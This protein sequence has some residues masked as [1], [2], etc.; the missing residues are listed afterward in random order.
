MAN[1]NSPTSNAVPPPS[2]PSIVN[3]KLDRSNYPLW[4]A[5]IVPLLNSRDLMSFVDGTSEC[6]PKN[7]AGSTTVN[8]AYTTWFQQDQLILSWINS[9]LTPSVLSTVSRNQTS[10]T[11]W[12]ALEHRYASASQNRILH[13]RNELLRTMKGDLSVSDY[14]DRMNAIRDN[15]A[16][17]GKPVDDD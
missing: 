1:T 11:T 13:L 15:L 17:S 12:Q 5:Q 10:R 3:I 4:L 16:L 2:I 14:L 7:V 9:S 8:P 6:P